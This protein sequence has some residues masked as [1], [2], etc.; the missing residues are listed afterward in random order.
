MLAALISISNGDI[1]SIGRLPFTYELPDGGLSLLTEI[2][3]E[4]PAHAVTYRVVEYI[5]AEFERPGT[6][7]TQGEDVE[8]RDGGV[9]TVTRE[10]TAWTQQEI[11]ACEA[12]RLDAVADRFDN[13][14]DFSRSNALSLN[15]RINDLADVTESILA[16]IGGASNVNDIKQAL[17]ATSP[18]AK[19]SPE[20]VK[21]AARAKLG[22][23]SD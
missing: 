13:L 8:T 17:V 7:Y 21:A 16:A 14:N 19:F 4:I 1:V 22:V 20:Q 3:Q 9:I 18:V 23:E 2:G 6:Y 11:D 12:A 10:W 15:D 5:E